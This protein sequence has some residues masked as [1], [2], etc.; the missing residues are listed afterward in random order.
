MALNAIQ[1]PLVAYDNDA[2]ITVNGAE[3]S[4]GS[5]DAYYVTT[6]LAR[7]QR[8]DDRQLS[9][10]NDYMDVIQ[11]VLAGGDAWDCNDANKWTPKLNEYN[12]DPQV[13]NAMREATKRILYTVA[14]SNAMNGVSPNMQIVE[15]RTWWQNAF[16]VADVVFGALLIVSVVMLVRGR[17]SKQTANK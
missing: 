11:G 5:G 9:N 16:I 17:K 15:V 4:I 10:S 12:D 14:N 7:E 2:T 8:I 3:V 13:V 1:A 6:T